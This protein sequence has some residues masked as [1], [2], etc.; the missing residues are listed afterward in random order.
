MG[1]ELRKDGGAD[2]SNIGFQWMPLN[3]DPVNVTRSS[4]RKAYWDPASNRP[5]LHLLVNSF[6]ST[7]RTI[8]RKA[9]GVD[10]V[11]RGS[12]GKRSITAAKE[13][14]LA[15]GA[16]H[17]PQILQLSGIGPAALLQKLGIEVV[18][19]L[20]GV[21]ANLQDHPAIRVVYQCMC[22]HSY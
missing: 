2:G 11:N 9:V 19:D 14:I 13:V 15:A 16:I 17:T 22:P 3:S 5:N 6:G 7:V 21:G 10:I 8:G 12:G 20:P 4:A 1:V 18:V